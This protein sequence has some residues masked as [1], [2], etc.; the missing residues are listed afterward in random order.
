MLDQFKIVSF[1]VLCV[2]NFLIY[3]SIT[4]HS[5]RLISIDI[6]EANLEKVDEQQQQQ[7]SSQSS[8]NSLT[9][10]TL[11]NNR[12]DEKLIR[13]SINAFRSL[14]FIITSVCI[15]AVDFKLFPPQH[16][17]RYRFGIS[18]MDIGVGFFILCH[19]MRLIRN[20]SNNETSHES[21]FKK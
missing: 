6:R 2:F 16:A 18:L 11:N 12:I 8:L 20:S 21:T 19:S 7:Q 17:K 1:L 10:T 4:S 5:N 15:L 13:I 3:K 14:L 9:T